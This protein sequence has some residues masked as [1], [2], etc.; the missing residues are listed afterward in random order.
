M[1]RPLGKKNFGP[2]GST[3]ST[4]GYPDTGDGR[5]I[6][7]YNTSSS[8]DVKHTGYNIPVYKARMQNSV[9][10][11]QADGANNLYILQQKGARRFKVFSA[12]SGVEVLKLADDDGSSDL[13]RGTMV[14][15]GFIGTNGSEA[16]Y[17][18]KVSGRKMYDF[19]GNA[20]TW[21][22]DNDSSANVLILTAI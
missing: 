22:V 9:M 18:R 21:Y 17:I 4:S 11:V 19:N 10:D 16:V 14:L 3:S 2:L 7:G 1:G 20:Y 5:D 12:A 6:H 8:S 13:A 15:R